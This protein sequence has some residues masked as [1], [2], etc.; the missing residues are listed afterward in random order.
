MSETYSYQVVTDVFFMEQG[1]PL[2][3]LKTL[4]FRRGVQPPPPPFGTPLEVHT[5]HLRI[6]SKNFVEVYYRH[7]GD[8]TILIATC[9]RK[10]AVG[11]LYVGNFVRADD[12]FKTLTQYFRGNAIMC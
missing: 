7:D 12:F 2:G 11:H 5:L 4:E 9:S 6:Y 1:I 3:F 8:H 10:D